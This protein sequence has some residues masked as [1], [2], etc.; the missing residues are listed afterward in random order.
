MKETKSKEELENTKSTIRYAGI[1][2][3]VQRARH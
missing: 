2:T 1:A 3:T